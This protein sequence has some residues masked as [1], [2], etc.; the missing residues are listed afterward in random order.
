VQCSTSSIFLD[1]I[2][3]KICSFISIFFFIHFLHN[4]QTFRNCIYTHI[5]GQQFVAQIT[6]LFLLNKI[7]NRN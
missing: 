5:V 1:F 7:T 3:T 6:F 4:P 2:N